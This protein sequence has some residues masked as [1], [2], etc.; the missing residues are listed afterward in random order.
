[1][2][3]SVSIPAPNTDESRPESEPIEVDASLTVS[4]DDRYFVLS[5]PLVAGK[6]KLTRLLIDPKSLGGRGFFNVVA[7][8][9]RQYPD[10]Y[11]VTFNLF[12]EINF[13][14]LVIARLNKITPEDLYKLD[15]TELPLL[16]LRASAF[17]YSGG[18]MKTLMES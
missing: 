12:S 16:M 13:L 7:E 8:F 1:M 17:Q 10:I 9:R 18:V 15:Y 2:E 14:S 11:R 4:D 3:P 5:K 6:E